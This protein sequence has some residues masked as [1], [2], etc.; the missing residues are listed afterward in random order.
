MI[1][2]S[3]ISESE[4]DSHRHRAVEWVDSD[5]EMGTGS[6]RF[7]GS[8]NEDLD[9]EYNARMACSSPEFVIIGAGRR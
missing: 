8:K 9:G 4:G 5:E 1:W 3:S 7:H 6:A 2:V